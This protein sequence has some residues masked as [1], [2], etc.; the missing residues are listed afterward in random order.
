MVEDWKRLYIE[1]LDI[2]YM[3]LSDKVKKEMFIE[4]IFMTYSY[5]HRM[6]NNEA[7]PK[8]IEL[9][10]KELMTGRGM[11]KYCYKQPLRD[12]G[13]RFLRDEIGLR[14]GEKKI[15]YIV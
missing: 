1:L 9:Y 15:V 14:F 13:E 12:E 2:L 6:I 5:V 4:V 8:A 10:D 7:F 3:S 11:G